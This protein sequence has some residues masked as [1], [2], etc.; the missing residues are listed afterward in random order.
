MP[1]GGGGSG[2][3]DTPGPRSSNKTDAYAMRSS[4]TVS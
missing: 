2:G 3:E 4:I 1:K